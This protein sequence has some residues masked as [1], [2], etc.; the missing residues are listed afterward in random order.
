[1][2]TF[3]I[4]IQK[5]DRRKDG[6]YPIYIRVY[7]KSKSANIHTDLY[8]TEKQLTKDLHL[9]DPMLLREIT[10]RIARYEELKLG[11]GFHIVAIPAVIPVT[12]G[13]QVI[14]AT[15]GTNVIKLSEWVMFHDDWAF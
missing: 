10:N 5:G 14:V 4:L 15:A 9:K 7:W 12:I 2:A 11:L 3:S 6:K 13:R 8:A 1:M